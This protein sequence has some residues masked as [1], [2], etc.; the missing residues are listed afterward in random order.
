M[1]RVC[2]NSAPGLLVATSEQAHRRSNGTTNLNEIYYGSIT[3]SIRNSVTT[4]PNHNIY[5]GFREQVVHKY[6]GN[7][8]TRSEQG[9]TQ[10]GGGGRGTRPPP[11]GPEKHYIF[12]VSSV[13]LRDL[14]I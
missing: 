8:P 10:G 9:R 5:R 12:R 7:V 11:L 2:S 13:K 1:G 6:T 3:G 14:H 4:E